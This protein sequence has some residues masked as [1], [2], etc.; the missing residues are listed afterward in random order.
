[1]PILLHSDDSIY[2]WNPKPADIEEKLLA[3][4]KIQGKFEEHRL[5]AQCQLMISSSSLIGRFSSLHGERIEREGIQEVQ[6]LCESLP[7]HCTFS[8]IETAYLG[9]CHLCMLVWHALPEEQIIVLRK[10][11]ERKMEAKFCVFAGAKTSDETEASKKSDKASIGFELVVAFGS[12]DTD[13]VRLSGKLSDT[14]LGSLTR[15]S[16]GPLTVEDVHQVQLSTSTSSDATLKLARWWINRCSRS[17]LLCQSLSNHEARLPSRLVYVGSLDGFHQPRLCYGRSLKAGTRYLTLSHAWGKEDLFTLRLHNIALLERRISEIDLPTKFRD[18]FQITRRLGYEYIWIDSL[19]I[20]QDSD[21][22]WRKEAANM[23]SVYGGTTCNIVA[24]GR[25]ENACFISRNPL[26][27]RPC[28]ISNNGVRSLSLENRIKGLSMAGPSIFERAW[29]FQE[30]LLAPRHLYFGDSQLLWECCT[31]TSSEEDPISVRKDRWYWFGSSTKQDFESIRRSPFLD[32]QIDIGPMVAAWFTLLES[33]SRTKITK[34]SDRL[35]AFSGVA[36]VIEDKYSL[37]YVA[38]MWKEHFPQNLLWE[39]L[40]PGEKLPTSITP[41]WSW[42]SMETQ[43]NGLLMDA[44]SP[45]RVMAVECTFEAEVLFCHS[46]LTR[47]ALSE[48]AKP[49]FLAIRGPLMP[50]KLT[51]G[52]VGNFHYAS[53]Q[54]GTY[55]FEFHADM[56]IPSFRNLFFFLLT[57]CEYRN[58]SEAPMIQFTYGQEESLPYSG[59]LE[60]SDWKPL[61][62]RTEK[63]APRGFSTKPHLTTQST[64]VHLPCLEAGLVLFACRD[65]RRDF[66]RVG[67]F[68]NVHDMGSHRPAV[69]DE[70]KEGECQG[71][72]IRLF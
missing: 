16:N 65:S 24:L 44:L 61:N 68:I 60:S 4:G 28:R 47:W 5:C 25:G 70:R 35:V 59:T 41:S 10:G 14:K 56:P 6:P 3:R 32:K 20:I 31:G 8:K 19:C 34:S 9:G 40:Y 39:A 21:E 72:I 17:H 29:V 33:Y 23:A 27:L 30:R 50:M 45:H 15:L 11:G 42:A 7:Y 36:R 58:K 26:K 52:E 62:A 53:V 18:A 55:R 64:T 66:T 67:I 49:S 1:M 48:T 43:G 38:G 63:F 69:F 12:P 54:G 51:E 22:D 37:T 71:R 57:R 2:P 46:R 13:I